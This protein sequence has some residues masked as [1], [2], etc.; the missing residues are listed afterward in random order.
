MSIRDMVERARRE[1]PYA[2]PYFPIPG[3]T[4]VCRVREPVC[5]NRKEIEKDL[6][7]KL[8]EPVAELW[9]CCGGMI[10]YE[11]D[12]YQ[13]SGLVVLSPEAVIAK[14]NAYRT[15]DA[16]RALPGDVVFA[17]F[18]GDLRLAVLRGDKNAADFGAVMIVAE[19][20]P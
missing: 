15:E 7:F 6:G 3:T 18:H 5:W 12:T 9:D 11:D 8:P 2:P 13:Q 20:D 10:L 4:F 17:E 1:S 14:N 19:M 16:D